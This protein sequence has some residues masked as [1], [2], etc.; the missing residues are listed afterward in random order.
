MAG[1]VGSAVHG[2][3]QME[4]GHGADGPPEGLGACP[5]AWGCGPYSGR[6]PLRG[7]LW[8]SVRQLGSPGAQGLVLED[9]GTASGHSSACVDSLEAP[10][11]A[12]GLPRSCLARGSDL[13]VSPPAVPLE[14]SALVGSVL[15]P[16]HTHTHLLLASSPGDVRLRASCRFPRPVTHSLLCALLIRPV[17]RKGQ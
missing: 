5:P 17:S 2:G 15:L 13:S 6:Q 3:R 11:W 10:T 14:G 7:L 16:P 8:T 9:P 1:G 12:S 4:R